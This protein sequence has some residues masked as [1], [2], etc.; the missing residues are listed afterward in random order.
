MGECEKRSLWISLYAAGTDTP[1]LAAPGEPGAHSG[2]ARSWGW[3]R[4]FGVNRRNAQEM[5]FHLL[6][7]IPLTPF[8]T[9]SC[10][11]SHKYRQGID[12]F[13][14]IVNV[15]SHNSLWTQNGGEGGGPIAPQIDLQLKSGSDALL[16]TTPHKRTDKQKQLLMKIHKH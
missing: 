4:A 7:R 16:P 14:A 13:L 1:G 2:R 15:Y 8:Q 9:N 5:G 11:L 10:M 3:H 12:A 6:C